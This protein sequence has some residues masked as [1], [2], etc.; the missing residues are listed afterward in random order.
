[1]ILLNKKSGII[2][3]HSVGCYLSCSEN[4]ISPRGLLSVLL[5]EKDMFLPQGL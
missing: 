4:V 2:I 5:K 3:G 1:M